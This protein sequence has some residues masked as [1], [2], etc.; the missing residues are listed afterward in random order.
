MQQFLR[1]LNLFKT[2]T[3]NSAP[4]LTPAEEQYL[5]ARACV[6]EQ[7]PT[8]MGL[9][10]GGRPFLM[11]D[12]L[13]LV[14]DNWLIFIGYP[15]ETEF[16]PEQCLGQVEQA[17][18]TYRPEVLWFIGPEIPVSLAETCRR[19]NSDEY[20]QLDLQ[21]LKL[22][23]SLR[24]AVKKAAAALTVDQSRSFTPEHQSLVT[25]FKQEQTL[26]PLIEA[27]YGAMPAYLAHSTTGEILNARDHRDRLV[28]F[29]VV[30]TAARPFDAYVLG[31]YSRKN[32]VP[33]ASDLLFFEM[34]ERSRSRGKST[35]NLGLGVNQGIRRFKKKW[36]GLPYLRYEFCE[37][38]FGRSQARTVVDLLLE[39]KL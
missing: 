31:C 27:L 8:L 15:L 10:S 28:A 16:K 34:I 33:Y 21:P 13:G 7:I 26:P 35:V 12:Y 29:Y 36:G 6:P 17:L 32:Y 2:R 9:I 1:G 24:R 39:G 38:Y 14:K 3:S 37:C 20:Y 11:G 5:L 25:E 19:R 30:E 23:S 18:Q 22:R 4:G